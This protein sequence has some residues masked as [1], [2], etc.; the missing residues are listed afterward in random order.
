MA[1]AMAQHH[2]PV[3]ADARASSK[4]SMKGY[5][6]PAIK[7]AVTSKLHT[8]SSLQNERVKTHLSSAGAKDRSFHR[9]Q[10]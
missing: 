2:R 9:L 7:L 1:F 4:L 5:H 8:P 10:R 3:G 6:R